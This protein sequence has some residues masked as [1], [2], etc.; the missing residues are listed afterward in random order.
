M[1]SP[2][3]DQQHT[4]S[5]EWNEPRL[6]MVVAGPARDDCELEEVVGVRFNRSAERKVFDGHGTPGERDDLGF[7][8]RP[9]GCTPIVLEHSGGRPYGISREPQ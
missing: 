5:G 6:A 8:E 1:P 3:R 4:A 2:D 7:S 9:H